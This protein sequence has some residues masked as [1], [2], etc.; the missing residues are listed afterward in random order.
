MDG[1]EVSATAGADE[2]RT[3]AE[4]GGNGMGEPLAIAIDGPAAS[5]KSTVARAVAAALDL[6][7]LDT[8][9][10]YRAVTWLAL[11]KG[12]DPADEAAVTRLAEGAA[13]DFPGRGE[14]AYVNLPIVIDGLDAT[15]GTREPA[16]DAAVSAVSSY[17]GVRAALVRRQQA[18]ARA[19]GV[20]M[21]GRD[22]GTVVL[23]G[24]RLKIYLVA[25]VDERARRRYAERVAR[26]EA[27]D[28]EEIRAAM[29]R[30]DGLDSARAHSPLRPASDAVHLDTTGLSSDAV[31]ERI[32]AMARSRRV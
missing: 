3:G 1:A 5:G 28:Y 12:V 16:V 17:Q 15:A 24:A 18:I 23:P 13:F 19:R 29:E 10:M 21:V 9:A 6:L 7:Y 26:G 30:R 11:Q 2:T 31:V 20:V 4:T 22:I 14:A 25:S 32:L 8:G 27:A